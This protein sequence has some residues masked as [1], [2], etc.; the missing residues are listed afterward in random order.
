MEEE[1]KDGGEKRWRI[2]VKKVIFGI[3]I[4]GLVMFTCTPGVELVY[5][6]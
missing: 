5:E 6:T 3:V 4:L 2:G 1:G